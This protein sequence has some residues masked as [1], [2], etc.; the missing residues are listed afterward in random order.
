MMGITRADSATAI[1]AR[2]SST[3]D[4]VGTTAGTVTGTALA[5]TTAGTEITAAAATMA[6][7]DEAITD[8]QPL[9]P[10]SPPQLAKLSL[11]GWIVPRYAFDVSSG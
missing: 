3:A 1:P 6:V 8:N 2:Y 7:T 4:T 9:N 5:D 11:G 10:R